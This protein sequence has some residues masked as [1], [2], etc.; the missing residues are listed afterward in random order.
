MQAVESPATSRARRSR[1]SCAASCKTTGTRCWAVRRW[2][3]SPC[4]VS[5]ASAY[6]SWTRVWWVGAAC[7]FRT[8]YVGWAP[9]LA[10][11]APSGRFGPW[12]TW[13][14]STAPF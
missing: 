12:C 3:P 13:A 9:V 5:A 14:G 7:T 8:Q 4:S 10:G 11:R 1:K 2:R 6:T